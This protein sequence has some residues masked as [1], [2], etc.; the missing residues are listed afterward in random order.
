L[1]RGAWRVLV[2]KSEGRRQLGRPMSRWE[3]HVK[4]DFEKWEG[5]WAV[6]IWLRIRTV[7]GLL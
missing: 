7:G 1:V 2:G 3:N 6:S 5:V 4:R